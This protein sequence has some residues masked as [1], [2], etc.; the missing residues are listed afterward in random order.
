M[1]D[2][3]DLIDTILGR[4]DRSGPRGPRSLGGGN[5]PSLPAL[6]PKAMVIGVLAL[7]VVWAALSTV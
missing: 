7:L 6:T 3:K 1:S 4:S 2:A 5:P